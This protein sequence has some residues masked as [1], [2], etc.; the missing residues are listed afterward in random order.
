MPMP[1]MP[2]APQAGM[3]M[4]GAPMG[5]VPQQAMVPQGQQG[6][7]GAWWEHEV[8]FCRRK[9]LAI[10]PTFEIFDPQGKPI[11][12]CQQKF[13]VKD[14][15]RVYHD[16]SQQTQIL[17]IKARSVVDWAG[18]FD[19]TDT[20]SGQ[21]LG[22]FRRKGW[23]SMLRD[24]WDILNNNGQPVG[25]IL[26]SGVAIMRRIFKFLPYKFD[27]LLNGQKVGFFHQHF[28]FFGYKATMSMQ[29]DPNR[30]FDRRLAMAGAMLLMAVEAREDA[31]R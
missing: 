6:M 7:A 10:R 22:A 16:K 21:I 12:F 9:I 24:E 18:V 11:L 26:E 15:I 19:V 4:P 30:M 23:R 14:D 28:S 20:A 2:M 5:A 25:K 31:N 17:G 3:P 13:S 29:A 1:G 27:F 8:V